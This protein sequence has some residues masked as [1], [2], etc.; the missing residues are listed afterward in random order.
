MDFCV[1]A[2]EGL[3]LNRD[4]WNSESRRRQLRDFVGKMLLAIRQ[5]DVKL[6]AKRK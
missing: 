4:I 1:A 2:I 5:G 6:P 3:L